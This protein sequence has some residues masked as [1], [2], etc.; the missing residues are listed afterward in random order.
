MNISFSG[1]RVLVSGSTAGIGLAIARAFAA[2]HASVAVNG[3]D[4][5]R[6]DS[7][8]KEMGALA[9]AADVAKASDAQTAAAGIKS[10]W[11]TLDI[12]VCNVGNGR[13]VPPGSE[14]PDEWERMLSLNLFS[15]TNLVEACLPLFPESGG[16][17]VCISSI[18]GVETLGAPVAYSAAKAALHA[19]VSGIARPLAARN[20]RINAVAP[21]NIH[22]PGGTWEHLLAEDEPKVR[23]MLDSQV[24][25]KRFGRPE[26]IAD[27]V[28][29]LA[30]DK[31]SFITGSV[32]VADGGQVRSHL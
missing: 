12:L 14:T 4:E 16:A 5:A 27:A 25:M 23:S 21:G 17:I 15:A 6:L 18:C 8:A 22:F 28:L 11:G 7:V 10:A 19:F 3:R 13:S 29:F 30:S 20:I 24:A 26:E 31:A 32:L 1:K 2:E 9:V